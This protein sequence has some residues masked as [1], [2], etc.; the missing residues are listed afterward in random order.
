MLRSFFVHLLVLFGLGLALAPQALAEVKIASVDFMRAAEGVGEWTQAQARLDAMFAEKKAAI[1]RMEGSIRQKQEDYE[2]Q[3]LLLSDA[4]KKQ[5]EEELQ[6]Q[7]MEYQQARAR[8][9]GE[10]QQA[11]LGAMQTVTEKM[12]K[13][14]ETI[15]A[16]RGYTLVIEVNEG[17]VLYT[18]SSI[19]ITDEVVKRYNAQNPS[20]ATPKK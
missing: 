11:Y 3:A 14:C 12:K 8:S 20:S 13:I 1:E 6:L 5:K 17:G 10:M 19:D 2:K 4:A 16:E 15:A 18:A 9:E 7:Y